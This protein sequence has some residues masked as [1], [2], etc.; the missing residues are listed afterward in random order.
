MIKSVVSACI[1]FASSTAVLAQSHADNGWRFEPEFSV[2]G[3]YGVTTLKDE[4][5]DED[6]TAKKAF[7]LV[8]FN[9]YIGLEGGYIDFDESSNE[10]LNFDPSGATLA[11]LL[12]APITQRFSVYAK[13]GQL[14]WDGEVS[15]NTDLVDANTDF[16][17]DETFW[18]LGAKFQLAEHLDLRVEYERFNF[19]I[20]QDEVNVLQSNALDMDV[21]YASVNLQYT[22]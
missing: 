3:G 19:E 22:F 8:K 11:L 10:A 6:E 5:F 1:I 9:E 17:G 4:D 20:E 18:G 15:L 14:W 2:G 13:G 7:A 16:D 21:D 12:E